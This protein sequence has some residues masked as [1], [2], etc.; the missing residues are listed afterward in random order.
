M[1][2]VS[3]STIICAEEKTYSISSIG[4]VYIFGRHRITPD[5]CEIIE[6][7]RK[8]EGLK[9]IYSIACFSEHTIC[10]DNLAQVFTFGSNRH[11]QLG[12]G[13]DRATL[14][15][16]NEIQK[17]KIPPIR[18]ISCGADFNVCVSQD[19]DVF[20]FGYN[21]DG[22]LGYKEQPKIEI[23]KKNFFFSINSEINDAP[24]HTYPHKLE[25]LKDIDFARCG[26]DFVICKSLNN[27]IFVWGFN[28]EYQLGKET[29]HQFIAEPSKC[30]GWPDNVVD[31]KCGSKH[32]IVLTSNGEVFACGS[33]RDGFGRQSLVKLSSLSDIIRIEC[34]MNH[35]L[36]IDMNNSL[37]I[38]GCNTYGQLGVCRSHSEN[39]PIKHP[40]LDSVIDISSGGE[41]TFVKTSANEIFAFGNSTHCRLGFEKHYTDPLINQPFLDSDDIWATFKLQTNAKSARK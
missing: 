30:S 16:T 24:E 26:K 5:E 20:V 33:Y 29:R 34:G 41:H 21:E 35:A 7:P 38:Y 19:G 6:K 12:I 31:I 25:S 15:F 28:R 36:F 3:T 22:Q 4:E 40:T 37:F 2:R 11:G 14:S 27:E 23:K 32:T 18:Q 39:P 1:A 8:F 10:L 17:V 13:K 9:N